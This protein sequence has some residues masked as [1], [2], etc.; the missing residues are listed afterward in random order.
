M[1]IVPFSKGKS[2][3]LLKKC[4]EKLPDNPKTNDLIDDRDTLDA[5]TNFLGW[6]GCVIPYKEEVNAPPNGQR[7]ITRPTEHSHKT[8][9][10]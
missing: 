10:N 8:S 4:K 3:T 6:A 2:L 7:F 5:P 1:Y 9:N